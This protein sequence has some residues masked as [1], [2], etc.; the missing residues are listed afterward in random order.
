M[1]RGEVVDQIVH[2]VDGTKKTFKGV[3]TATIEQ[4]EFTHFELDDGRRI[5][6]NTNNVNCFEVLT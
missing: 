4:S 3:K 6:I 5:Y 1:D 2:F